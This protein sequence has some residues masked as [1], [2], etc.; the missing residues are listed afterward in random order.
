MILAVT[1]AALAV[2]QGSAAAPAKKPTSTQSVILDINA[3]SAED[4]QKMEGVGPVYADKIIKGRPYR[5]KNE[6]LSK[7]IVP[8]ATYNKIKDQIIAKQK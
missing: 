2:A 7:K 1:V 3:A 5:A 4:L 8:A 6:L